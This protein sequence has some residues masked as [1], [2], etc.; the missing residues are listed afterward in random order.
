MLKKLLVLCSM[1]SIVLFT[2]CGEKKELEVAKEKKDTLV[3]AQ[4]SEGKTL[5]PQD[6]TEQYSQVV[7]TQIYDRLV[8]IDEMKG[9]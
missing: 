1:L 8:E 6:S 4:L 3:Y 7:T 5:D 2:G 9:K